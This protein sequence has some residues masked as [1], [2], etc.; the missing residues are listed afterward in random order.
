MVF[1]QWKIFNSSKDTLYLYS[2]L[3]FIPWYFTAK[4]T[5]ITNF[6]KMHKHIQFNDRYLVRRNRNLLNWRCYDIFGFSEKKKI[7]KDT[8]LVIIVLA[9]NTSIFLVFFF[10]RLSSKFFPP[11]C[12]RPLPVYIV[13]PLAKQNTS[14]RAHL[15]PGKSI[16][17]KISIVP[18]HLSRRLC[19]SAGFQFDFPHG[20]AYGE[21]FGRIPPTIQVP[22]TRN[23]SGNRFEHLNHH[24]LWEKSRMEGTRVEGNSREKDRSGLDLSGFGT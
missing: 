6:S 21:V 16:T 2:N 18:G 10:F 19:E 12:F 5:W 7:K 24:R 22:R 20:R 15:Y 17:A 1:N 13:T 4:L 11:F 3:I 14:T 23:A 9:K 8:G